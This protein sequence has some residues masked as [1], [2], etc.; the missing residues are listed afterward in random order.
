MT[1][2][3]EADVVLKIVHVVAAIVAL[4]SNVTYGVWLQRAGQDRERL[5]FVIGGIRTLDAIRPGAGGSVRAGV[6]AIT[7]PGTG[8]RPAGCRRAR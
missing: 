6:S 1:V 5:K 8:R 2:I 7:S 4:G 3:L